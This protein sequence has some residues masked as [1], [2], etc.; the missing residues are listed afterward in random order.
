MRYY[1]NQLGT[2]R[3]LAINPKQLLNMTAQQ[4]AFAMAH[5]WF[6]RLNSDNSVTV[7]EVATL[8]GETLVNYPTF[9]SFRTLLNWAG[10]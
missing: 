3:P 10:Y 9:S 7:R 5:D 8:N 2:L 4:I 1:V 6:V